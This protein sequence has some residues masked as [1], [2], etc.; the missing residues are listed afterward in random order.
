MISGAEERHVIAFAF[1]NVDLLTATLSPVPALLNHVD[2]ILLDF[3][4][5]AKIVFTKV[6]ANREL[7]I[8]LASR[9]SGQY[10]STEDQHP[11]TQGESEGLQRPV[12]HDARII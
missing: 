11:Y 10:L 8:V 2:G 12:P 5:D 1:R 6:P 4:N 3:R 9:V 7:T